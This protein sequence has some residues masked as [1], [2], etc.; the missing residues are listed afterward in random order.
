[1]SNEEGGPLMFEVLPELLLASP[2]IFLKP[3]DT[4]QMWADRRTRGQEDGHIDPITQTIGF[5]VR[6]I[7][8]YL[9]VK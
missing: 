7:F 6:Y 2:A 8:L 9:L 3:P 1:M 4:L 5:A